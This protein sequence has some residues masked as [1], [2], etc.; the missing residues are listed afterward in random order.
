MTEV[1]FHVN[2]ADR[3]GYTC[4]LLRKALRLGQG[5]AVTGEAD[6][7][8]ELDRQLWVF[9]QHEFLPHVRL[10]AGAA[11]GAVHHH[12]RLWLVDD[13]MA[14]AH[15]PVLVNLGLDAPPGFA[16]YERLIE[17]VSADAEELAAGRRRWKHYQT[18]GYS[19]TKHEVAA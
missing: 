15:L 14:A 18:R 10:P 6:V 13:P 3:M 8:A 19:V 9:E 1:L 16:S 5:V 17:V 7:L 12:T 2:V 11:P 4:R